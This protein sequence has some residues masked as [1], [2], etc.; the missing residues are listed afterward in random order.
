VGREILPEIVKIKPF[1]IGKKGGGGEEVVKK[2]KER[3]ERMK[4]V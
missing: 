4:D 2:R 1:V 3:G